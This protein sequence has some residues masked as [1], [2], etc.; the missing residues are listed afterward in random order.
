MHDHTKRLAIGCYSVGLTKSRRR[1]AYQLLAGCVLP[2]KLHERVIM[3][4]ECSDLRADVRTAPGSWTC[5]KQP[6]TACRGSLGLRRRI[7]PGPLSNGSWRTSG[8]RSSS[9]VDTGYQRFFLLLE[10]LIISVPQDMIC[11]SPNFPRVLLY[12][13][14]SL[15][16]VLGVMGV[17]NLSF[18]HRLLNHMGLP[19]DFKERDFT[20]CSYMSLW[21]L[22]IWVAWTSVD[23]WEAASVEDGHEWT[24]TGQRAGL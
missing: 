22:P 21:E 13:S 12:T 7:L 15:S 4:C 5:S 18:S 8:Q 10:V 17:E 6:G 2:Q 16:T 23:T 19:L 9:L 1:K 3:V 14:C 20:Q 24:L 11:S